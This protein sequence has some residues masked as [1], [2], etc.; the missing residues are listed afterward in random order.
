MRTCSSLHHFFHRFEYNLV[1]KNIGL[2]PDRILIVAECTDDQFICDAAY[3]P[4]RGRD[5]LPLRWWCDGIV[6]CE[7]ATDEQP[8]CSM[9]PYC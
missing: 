9:L 8:G 1:T 7:N 5:C 3:N 2:R 4:G 6:D